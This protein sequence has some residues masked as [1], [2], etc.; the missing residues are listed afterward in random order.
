MVCGASAVKLK[1]TPGLLGDLVEITG[2]HL[3]S[4]ISNSVDLELVLK[5]YISIKLLVG[6]DTPDPEP[7]F[8]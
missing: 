6:F 1:H 7:T 3:P 8:G 4:E 5:V 2:I